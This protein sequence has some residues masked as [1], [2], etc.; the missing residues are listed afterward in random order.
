M[1][2][3]MLL[4]RPILMRLVAGFGTACPCAKPRRQGG[5]STGSS[6]YYRRAGICNQQGRWIT[7]AMLFALLGLALSASGAP[8]QPVAV[9]T[10][11]T[12][13]TNLYL[14]TGTSPA[15][16]RQSLDRARPWRDVADHDARTLWTSEYKFKAS[17]EEGR[18]ALD[19]FDLRVK[20]TMTLPCWAMP[21]NATAQVRQW[22]TDYLR[23][24]LAH[25][26]GHVEIVRQGIAEWAQRIRGMG[27]YAGMPQLRVATGQVCTN[28]VMVI[29][30]QEADYDQRTRHGTTQGA[31][32]RA[33]DPPPSAPSSR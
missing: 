20:V 24:L 22:W 12:A 14:V 26:Q 27:D 25:E 7:A 1:V 28:A 2:A 6:A 23:G 8:G 10:Q 5:R 15:E 30:R 29:R 16:V 32:L 31:V 13:S 3:V 19:S 9:S 11:F 33:F 17:A 4:P 18:F 21:T